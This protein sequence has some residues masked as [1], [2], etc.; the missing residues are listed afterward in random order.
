VSSAI[1]ALLG[2]GT[3][4]AGVGD[5]FKDETELTFWL[6]V[7]SFVFWIAAAICS[8]WVLAGNVPEPGDSPDPE[9]ASVDEMLSFVPRWADHES[10]IL[11]R[12]IGY[13]NLLI[14]TALLLTVASIITSVMAD[15]EPTLVEA[16]VVF[17]DSVE[18]PLEEVCEQEFSPVPVRILGPDDLDRTS[19]TVQMEIIDCDGTT[20]VVTVLWSQVEA[21]VYR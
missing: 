19:D 20:R 6:I 14:G 13:A 17:D 1:A 9:G 7:L 2:F 10:E 8:L 4:V 11:R 16:E 18:V 21:L 15:A 12:R 3:L 5:N